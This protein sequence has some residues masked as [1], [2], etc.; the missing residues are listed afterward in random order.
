MRYAI[1]LVATAV[2]IAGCSTSSQMQMASDCKRPADRIVDYSPGGSII[3]TPAE[4]IDV[5]ESNVVLTW[6]I[7]DAIKN[8]YEFRADSIEIRDS[9]DEF[10]NCKAG[11]PGDVDAGKKK[12]KCTDKN[13]K[14][15]QGGTRT[16]KYT[17]RIYEQNSGW[18]TEKDPIIANN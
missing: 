17:I 2:V 13:A 18:W 11:S 8:R 14:H 10:M 12:I 16:Y 5:C 3:I 7:H 1:W 15:G 6:E 9:D 4:D